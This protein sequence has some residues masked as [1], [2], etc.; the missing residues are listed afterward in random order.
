VAEVTA[1]SQPE[2][3]LPASNA[4][5]GGLARSEDPVRPAS[6]GVSNTVDL[7]ALHESIAD[8][9]AGQ[10]DWRRAYQ[11]LRSALDLAHAG[12]LRDSLTA[13][14]N[15]R[16]LDQRLHGLLG[17]RHGRAG[18]AIALIDLDLFKNVNDTFGHMV[19][20]VV[21]RRVAELLQ[22]GLP[23]DGFC[24]RYGGE[25][26]ALVLPD[27]DARGAL[28]IAEATRARVADHPWSQLRPGLA[29]TISVGI[30]HETQPGPG[31]RQLVHADTLLYAAK[32]AGRN[33]VAYQGRE[34]VQI[35]RH[36]Q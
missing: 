34:S 16:Y 5:S 4:P 1:V 22:E 24:A 32:R 9:L 25:E 29:V 8:L 2:V 36:R 21:L 35:V 13:S 31:Q 18:V 7:V 23:A 6:G 3:V 15:R 19:G 11:H 27:V 33:A 12:S 28:L 26:F 20:D 10:G 14:Y 30:A 17:D